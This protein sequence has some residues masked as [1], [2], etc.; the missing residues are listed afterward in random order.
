MEKFGYRFSFG[1]WNIHEGADPFGPTVRSAVLFDK[2]VE[3]LKGL[4]YD[5]MQFHDD[6]VVPDL[7]KLSPAEISKQA[8]A[9]RAKLTEHGLVAEFVA[10]RL[11]ESPMTVDGAYTANDPK[12]RQYAIDRSKKAADIAREVGCNLMVLWLAREGTYMREAKDAARATHYLLEAVN[13]L[14]DYDK[15]L[16]IA[17]ETKPNEPMDMAYLPTIGHALALGSQSD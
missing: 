3:I 9:I 13:T 10:P 4:G 8:Q 12:M 14:L 5:A 15:D 17:I 11:W 1:P 7:D 2:K 6:D 16:R